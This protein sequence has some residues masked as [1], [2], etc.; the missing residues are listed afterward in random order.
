MLSLPVKEFE[1][2]WIYE[3]WNHSG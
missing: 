3:T 1:H 2:W